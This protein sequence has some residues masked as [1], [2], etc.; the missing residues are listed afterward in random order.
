MMRCSS[1]LLTA[2]AATAHA[3]RDARTFAV[4]RFYGDGPLTEG[5][6]DPIISPGETSSHVHT[7]MGGS[8][9]GVS[10]TGETMLASGC[11]NALV[12][13][14]NSGYWVPKLYF[15]DRGAGTLEPVDLF[16]MNVVSGDAGLRACPDFGGA[17]QTDG[18]NGTAGVQPAQWTCPRS[19]YDPPSWPPATESDGSAA[20]I[21]DP[22]DAQAG[23][24][25][26]F[27]ECDGYASPLR[28]DLHLPSC[29][30]PSKGLAGVRAGN[31]VFPTTDGATG[32]Q[33]CPEGFLHVPHL[34]FETYWNTPVFRDRWTPNEGYQPFVLS[35][36]DLTGCSA[37]GDFLA[38]WDTD[39]L[40]GIIDTCDAGDSGMDTCP[41]VKHQQQHQQH[42]RR[43]RVG[44]LVGVIFGG[45]RVFYCFFWERRRD[46]AASTSSAAVA[47]ANSDGSGDDSNQ[48]DVVSSSP[49]DISTPTAAS[50]TQDSLTT[51]S[52]TTL[53][54]GEVSTVWDTIFYTVTVTATVYETEA[55]SARKERRVAEDGRGHGHGHEHEHFLRHRSPHG[56]S[57]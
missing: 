29:Y 31:M 9:M 16:Y 5:R 34:F 52:V 33:N 26:P 12:E 4:L 25:F 53:P 22:A 24:G 10:A 6:V 38:A 41:G 36:G 28:Q 51:A 19:A 37:H 27:A 2:L 49:A 42:R 23:Q 44:V 3:A 46:S 56:R 21:Q 14:D 48:A 17:L 18:A 1:P 39:V 55:P 7:I 43:L 57:R 35:N 40:Q 54:N 15:H 50:V 30:D 32:K 20:G 11:S 47:L 13:G 8:N 45:L